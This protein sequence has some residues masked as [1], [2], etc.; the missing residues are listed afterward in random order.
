MKNKLYAAIETTA[1]FMLF[2]LGGISSS[3]AAILENLEAVSLAGGKV[4]LKLEFDGLPP[5]ISGYSVEK[6]ASITIYLLDTQSNV[7]KYHDI[8]LVG[9]RNVAVLEANGRTRLMISLDNAAS[10]STYT[11]GSA[12][13]VL[14]N[15]DNTSELSEWDVDDEEVKKL[16]D[17]SISDI[18][19]YRGGAGEGNVVITLGSSDV[20]MELVEKD[21]RL[22]LLFS[23]VSLPENLNHRFDVVDFATPV[24]FVDV[25]ERDDNTL[26]VIEPEGEYDYLTWQTGKKLTVS[27]K[28]MVQGEVET[29]EQEKD[30]YKGENISFNFQNINVRSVL[31]LIADFRD[32]NLVASDTVTGNITL[33]L[34]N[35]PWD[36]ALDI[37]LKSSG[38]D[39]RLLNNVLT[40]APVEE[41]AARERHKLET[42][43]RM[44]ELAPLVSQ[45]IQI[46]YA[47][48]EK[49]SAVL[50]GGKGNR[51]LSQRGSVQVVERTN[52]LLVQETQERLDAI[53]SLVKEID[54]P[55]KQVQ[56]EARIVTADSSFQKNLGVKWTGNVGQVTDK[57]KVED[58]FVDLTTKGSAGFTWGFVTDNTNL[59]LELSALEA[60]GGGEVIS[61]PKIVTSDKQTAI[62][63]NGTE[64]PYQESS[65][66]GAT[67]TAFKEA[68]LSLE[69]TPQ[70]TPDNRVIMDI[71]VTND[72]VKSSPNG[73]VPSIDK[74]EV[75]TKVLVRDGETLVIGGI[76]N[77][78]TTQ[79][80]SKVP[81]LGDL[82]IVGTLFNRTSSSKIK[83]EVLIFITPKII[84]DT[85]DM[86]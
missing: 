5:E 73:S 31:Q 80:K 2:S 26:I 86:H 18:N 6:P 65:S 53:L 57:H 41:L 74:N 23:G 49:I 68:V 77:N 59:S 44:S 43:K 70:I 72:S 7:S 8:G 45:V 81:L 14:I 17:T 28:P 42:L 66:S 38:L 10:Y 64:I 71:K 82:P 84:F 79:S 85:K 47:D 36:Q 48:A 54:V 12:L 29:T 56:I 13:Y 67:S 58:L 51:T 83:K 24:K 33:R 34:K 15:D 22:E 69:V 75:Q 1:L 32:L 9:A 4:E 63:K 61:Q 76:F 27:V 39:K 20:S 21:G 35:V 37:V 3:F 78:I 25:M 55:V 52:S 16:D 40:V 62:I 11:E 19:F 46:N 60:D 30:L 50:L